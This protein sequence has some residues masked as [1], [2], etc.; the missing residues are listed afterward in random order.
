VKGSALLDQAKETVAAQKPFEGRV[1][2]LRKSL[3]A[4]M[5]FKF[6]DLKK[7]AES[8]GERF[9][10]DIKSLKAR[11]ISALEEYAQSPKGKRALGSIRAEINYF[12]D[13]PENEDVFDIPEELK[14]FDEKDIYQVSLTN[15]PKYCQNYIV[16]AYGYCVVEDQDTAASKVMKLSNDTA[17][18]V[19]IKYSRY[20]T[21]KNA[22]VK[23]PLS[24]KLQQEGLTVAGKDY[25]REDLIP[26][27]Y[28]LYNIGSVSGITKSHNT[29]L[30]LVGGAGSVNL[31][32]LAVTFPMDAC[33]VYLS[34]KFTGEVFGGKTGDEN[35]IYFDRMIV[36]RK[37]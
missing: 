8:N 20:P 28:H 3:D 22:E 4:V 33:D 6:F 36:V 37:Q 31:S 29:R 21:S 34:M 30:T 11:V 7:M 32:G 13:L 16:K 25:Y 35:A 14:N 26:N 27:G 24:F 9:D 5:S 23:N 17:T 12:S 1:N 18:G 2:W 19:S 15:M 10:F